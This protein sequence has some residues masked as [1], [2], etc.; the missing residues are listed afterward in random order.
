M[1]KGLIIGGV[2]FAVLIALGIVGYGYAQ[3]QSIPDTF[4]GYGQGYGRG[5]MGGYAGRGGMMGGWGDGEYG[6]LHTYMIE[7]IA[8]EFGLTP[9][10]VEDLH[11]QGKTLW[12][13]AQEQGLTQEQFRD[14]MVA[15]RTSAL[16]KAVAAGVITQAQADWMV[17]RMG[18]MWE[19][20]AGSGPCHG[21]GRF[22]GR[23][24]GW[25][26]NTPPTG[27]NG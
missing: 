23:G 17:E 21:G 24:P 22:G 14:K 5:M 3:A 16:D 8:S 6:P 13:Y 11:D 19:Y 20:G 10:A 9:T 15:A 26:S 4:N 7:A 1:K 2:V 12:E 25:N 18:Q 27:S